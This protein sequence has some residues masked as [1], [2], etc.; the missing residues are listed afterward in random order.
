[1]ANFADASK[2]TQGQ[3]SGKAF[4]KQEE[5]DKRTYKLST[6]NEEF[7]PIPISSTE[8]DGVAIAYF[9]TLEINGFSQKVYCPKHNDGKPCPACDKKDAILA[10]QEKNP[11]NPKYAV[12]S[13]TNTEIFKSAMKF[14]PRKCYIVRGVDKGN[15]KEGPKF[16][17]VFENGKK[18]GLWDKLEPVAEDYAKEYSA[19][20]SDIEKGCTIKMTCVEKVFDGNKYW[21]ASMIKATAPEA[22]SPDKI[23]EWVADP[24]VWRDVF[25]PSTLPGYNE[26]Q[27]IQAALDKTVPKWN[28]ELKKF[29]DHLGNVIESTRSQPTTEASPEVEHTNASLDKGTK[30]LTNNTSKKSAA[31]DL[32]DDLP[33]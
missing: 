32:T 30:V 9:H 1:M 28:K 24:V 17:R 20:L 14:A 22:L 6:K 3:K 8:T 27:Y 18:E 12:K 21:D 4:L 11:D 19:D 10:T 16:L 13:E 29:V 5:I 23:E 2:N 31:A 33:F 25:R 7:R 26:Q 15:A